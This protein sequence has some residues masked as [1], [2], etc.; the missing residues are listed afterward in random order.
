MGCAE[1]ECAAEGVGVS[2]LG[3]CGGGC[4]LS[5]GTLHSDLSSG[6]GTHLQVVFPS[7]LSSL[8]DY[9][10]IQHKEVLSKC[11]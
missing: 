2:G 3:V 1:P 6:S 4:W 9:L 10:S 7:T 8:F 11:F 5:M